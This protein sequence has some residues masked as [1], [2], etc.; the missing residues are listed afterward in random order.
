[1]ARDAVV[2][3]RPSVL[4]GTY[5]SRARRRRAGWITLGVGSAVGMAVMLSSLAFIGDIVTGEGEDWTAMGALL[6]VGGGILLVS[7]IVG[8][9]LAMAPDRAAIRALPLGISM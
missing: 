5:T 9:V 6:G 4:E 3:D 2:V 7:E 1:M 8:L